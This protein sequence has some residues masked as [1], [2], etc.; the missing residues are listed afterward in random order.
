MTKEK[1][2]EKRKLNNSQDLQINRGFEL[3]LRHNSRGGNPSKP[4]AFQ[5]RFGKM[6]SL[7]KREIHFQI[8]FFFDMKKK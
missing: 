2:G 3:M 7:L 8:D 5:F 6:L 1:E 4:K